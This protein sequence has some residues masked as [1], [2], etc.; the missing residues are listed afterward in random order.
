MGS[1]ELELTHKK[2]GKCLRR[3]LRECKGPPEK[4][5][6]RSQRIA[7]NKCHKHAVPHMFS[8]LIYAYISMVLVI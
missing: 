6:V 3:I 5:K 1:K 7:E 8:G 4:V 2:T